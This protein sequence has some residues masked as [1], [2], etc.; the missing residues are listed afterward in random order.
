MKKG[1]GGCLCVGEMEG[2]LW[3]RG[4]VKGSES[5]LLGHEVRLVHMPWRMRGL[6]G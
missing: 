6:A 5:L 1:G 4:R 2:R 3:H